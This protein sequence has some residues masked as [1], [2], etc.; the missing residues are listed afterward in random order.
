MGK[1]LF[2]YANRNCWWVSRGLK[3]CIG[4]LSVVLVIMLRA[5]DIQTI[6]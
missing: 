3:D 6:A 1:V 5:D 2:V 4:N